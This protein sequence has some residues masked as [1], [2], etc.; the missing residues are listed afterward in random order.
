LFAVLQQVDA[1]RPESSPLLI[2]AQRKH[3]PALTAP[4]DKHTQ[5]QFEELK[6]WVMLTLA[7]PDAATPATIEVESPATLAQAPDSTAAP[8][9]APSAEESTPKPPLVEKFTPRDPFDPE[10]FNRRFDGA[11]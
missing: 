11:K 2:E 10:I 9:A 8:P 6:A 7:A 1:S 4:L 5:R 3:G